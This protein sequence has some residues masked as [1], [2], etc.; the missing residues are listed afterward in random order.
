VTAETGWFAERLYIDLVPHGY[1][2][3]LA[4]RSVICRERSPFQ[5]V[6][7]FDNPRFGRVLALDGIIQTTEADEFIYHEM[8]V[9]VPLIA[10]GRARRVLIVGGGDGGALRQVLRHPVE[11]VTLVE[12]DRTVIDLCRAHMPGVSNGAF[13]DPRLDLVIAD[14]LQ[15]LS[16][17]TATFDVVI[18]DGP[19]PVGPGAALFTEAFYRLAHACL[20]SGGVFVAQDGSPFFAPQEVTETYR[21]L[22]ALFADATVYLAAVP[23]YVAAPLAIAYASDNPVLRRLSLAEVQARCRALALVGHYYSPEVHL[24]A[25]ALP[26]MVARLLT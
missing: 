23:S 21:R 24:A 4:M 10:H 17:T 13:D 15:Y 22:K 8:L 16:G 14:G 3:R 1:A 9:H 6:L 7:I 18:V 5:E 12:I 19:D 2:Q 11:R 20:L 26:P 25:F